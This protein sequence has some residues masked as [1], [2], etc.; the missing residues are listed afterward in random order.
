MAQRNFS[1]S[2][3]GMVGVSNTISVSCVCRVCGLISV[4][5]VSYRGVW[6]VTDPAGWKGCYYVGM[7]DT[8]SLSDMVYLLMV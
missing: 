4:V 6:V 7:S 5:T 2:T 3:G 8:S 1:V